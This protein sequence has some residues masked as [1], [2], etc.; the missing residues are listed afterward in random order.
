MSASFSTSSLGL[1]CLRTLGAS[2]AVAGKP[3]FGYS[4]PSAKLPVKA[5][6]FFILLTECERLA[7]AVGWPRDVLSALTDAPL[8]IA[9]R[10][11]TVC[12]RCTAL[13]FG[14]IKRLKR[15]FQIWCG[16]CFHAPSVARSVMAVTWRTKGNLPCVSI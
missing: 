6:P 10:R 16:D 1:V 13:G 8:T 2:A 12:N 11:R 3:L 4:N 15:S 9:R 14:F 5:H 7:I